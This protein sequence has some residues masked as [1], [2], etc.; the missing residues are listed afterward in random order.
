MAIIIALFNSKR[1]QSRLA[2]NEAVKQRPP[3]SE[4]SMQRP[5]TS[6]AKM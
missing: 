5:V 2:P 6:E 4:A 1:W 3:K